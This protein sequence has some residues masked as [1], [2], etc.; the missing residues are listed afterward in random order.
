MQNSSSSEIVLLSPTT[1]ILKSVT[2]AASDLTVGS[3]VT[4]T[5]TTNSDGSVSATSIQIRPAGMN[6]PGAGS[7]RTSTG[8]T[9]Q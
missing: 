5:G 3:E 8:A 7:A 4:I 2:G 9:S 1:Q 6:Y